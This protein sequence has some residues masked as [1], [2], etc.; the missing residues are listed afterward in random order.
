MDAIVQEIEKVREK[1]LDDFIP[2]LASKP[3]NETYEYEGTSFDCPIGKFYGS[4][5]YFKNAG[6][7][8]VYVYADSDL[9][10]APPEFVAAIAPEP[11]TYGD[12]L[13]RAKSLANIVNT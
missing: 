6:R 8:E 5:A 12:A 3:A 9:V 10:A 13:W 4:P 11:H 2:W 7:K 1:T